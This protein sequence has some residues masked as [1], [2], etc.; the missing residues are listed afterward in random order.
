MRLS[1]FSKQN[2]ISMLNILYPPTYGSI[3]TSQLTENTLNAQRNAY[4]RYILAVE[5]YGKDVLINLEQASRR[6]GET[7]GWSVVR[8]I[9]DVYLFKANS[10]IDDYRSAKDPMNFHIINKEKRSISNVSASSSNSESSIF[11][12]S[13]IFSTGPST[14]RRPTTSSCSSS[15]ISEASSTFSHTPERKSHPFERFTR[16]LKSRSTDNGSDSSSQ[17]SKQPSFNDKQMSLRKMKSAGGL[18]REGSKNSKHSRENSSD[19]AGL[20]QFIID[21]AQR[22]RLIREAQKDKANNPIK[23]L[24]SPPSPDMYRPKSR[25]PHY[26]IPEEVSPTSCRITRLD[27]QHPYHDPYRLP[28]LLLPPLKV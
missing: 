14:E 23:R 19:R 5:K 2:C 17:L 7:N 18:N 12:Q 3:P 9:V 4:F 10:L 15:P 20:P 13:S 16:R 25:D 22:E 21:D 27:H 24:P 6:S 28:N 1:P 8:D 11:S 26:T